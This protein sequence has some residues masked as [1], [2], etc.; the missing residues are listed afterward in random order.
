LKTIAL[1]NMKG[2]TGKTSISVSL[3]AELAKTSQTALLDFDPQGN[4]TAWMAPDDADMKRELADVLSGKATAEDAF[5]PTE[6][7]G[8]SLLPTFGI[9]GDLGNYDENTGEMKITNAVQDLLDDTARQGF[10]YCVIDLS[11]AFGKLERAALIAASEAITPIMADRFSI[12]G[13]RAI[14]TKLDEL[15]HMARRPI[16]EYKRII[17]NGLNRSIKRH[18]EITAAVRQGY[19]QAVY[20]LPIDQVFFRAQTSSRTI[21]SMDAKKETLD[22]FTRLANDIKGVTEQ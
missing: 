15:K 16:A 2:G 4:T 10:E 1:A 11:P 13:L 20:T 22:E 19:K 3:A 12:D 7:P 5:I 18:A 21:Q 8:L 14:T 9:A 6:T 17:I